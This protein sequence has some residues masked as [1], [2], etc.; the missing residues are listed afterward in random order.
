MYKR[1]TW[2]GTDCAFLYESGCAGKGSEID[3]VEGRDF[4]VRV[5]KCNG[6]A[7]RIDY[8]GSPLPFNAIIHFFLS[9][10]I[11]LYF[12]QFGSRRREGVGHR[13]YNA[14]G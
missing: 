14:N 2:R 1:Q 4:L 11:D 6:E 3:K 5:F 8:G 12:P 7:R 9:G 10:D 13:W